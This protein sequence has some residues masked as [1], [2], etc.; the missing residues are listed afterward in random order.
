MPTR[1]DYPGLQDAFESKGTKGVI[2]RINSPGEPRSGGHHQQRNPQAEAK[3]SANTALCGG[4]RYLRF[5][6]YYVAAGSGSIY[7]DRASIVGSIGVL[8][9][10]FGFYG[11]MK[12]SVSSAGW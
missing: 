7:V 4:G 11:T 1:R 5:R 8:M 6:R 12:S 9:D 10:G 3:I 2:L